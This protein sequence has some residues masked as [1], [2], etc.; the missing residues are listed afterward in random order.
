MEPRP[1]E[2]LD[3]RALKAWFISGLLIGALLL[4]LPAA[5]LVAASFFNLPVIWGWLGAALI[6][7]I[8]FI[9]AVIVP[10]LRLIYWRYE[11]KEHEIDIQRGIIVITR[12]LVPMV[13]IQ[14]VDT[15]H[16]PVMRHFGLATLRVSTAA[17]AHR[18]PALSRE[19][20]AKLRGEISALARVSDE[21]V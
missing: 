18:I 17:T 15:E 8:T 1:K 20:A 21:D 6:V 13:R 11:L 2:K 9:L 10:R 3:P 19:T 5:Y 12:T 16:G 4:L 7:L 14:H